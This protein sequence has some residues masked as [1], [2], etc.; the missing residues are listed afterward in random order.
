VS[1]D[2]LLDLA[3][4]LTDGAPVDWDAAQGDAVAA[5]RAVVERLHQLSELAALHAAVGPAEPVHESIRSEQSEHPEMPLKWGPLEILDKIGRGSYGD[6]YRARDP[7][8]GREVALKLLRRPAGGTPSVLIHE[9][10]LL[11]RIRHPNVVTVYGADEFDGRTGLW[12]ELVPGETLEEELRRRGPFSAED[13]LKVAADLC[14]AVEAVHAAGLLHRDIKAQNVIRAEDGRFVLMDFGTGSDGE[15]GSAPALAG[16]PVYLAPETFA[17]AA[18]TTASDVYALGVLL[19]HLATG[20]YPIDGSDIMALGRAHAKGPSKSLVVLRADYPRAVAAAIDRALAPDPLARFGDVAQFRSSLSQSAR[21]GFG[22]R[23]IAIATAALL[24]AGVAVALL[25]NPGVFSWRAGSPSVS[26]SQVPLSIQRRFNIRAPSWEGSLATCTPLGPGAVSLCNL[27]DGSIRA[28]RTPASNRERAPHAVLSPDGRRVAYVWQVDQVFR[29]LRLIDADSANDRE[30][31][32][33]GAPIL[34]V[35]GWNRASNALVVVS[36]GDD[37]VCVELLEL[38]TAARQ[39]LRCD[40]SVAALGFASLSPDDRYLAY[41]KPRTVG[42]PAEDVWIRD[43]VTGTDRVVTDDVSIDRDV[44]WTPDGRALAFASNRHGTWGLFTIDVEN[45]VPEGS[46][47]LVRDLGRSMPT[48]LGFTRDGTLFV[49]MLTDLEDVLR[50]DVDLPAS[51]LG[52]PGRAEPTALDET[53]RSP[54]WSPDGQRFAYIAGGPRADARIVIASAHGGV[55]KA[56]TF[57]GMPSRYEIVRWSPDGRTLAVSAHLA[58]G[59]PVSTLDLIDLRNSERRRVLVADSIGDLRWAPNGKGIYY[60][61]P[62]AIHLVDLTT[63]VSR[64]VYRPD[65]PWAIERFATFDL[66]RDGMALVVAIRTKGVNCAARIITTT[67]EVRDL[68]PFPSDCRAIAWTHDEQ[69][70]LASVYADDGSI[71][72]Y[73]VPVAGGAKPVRLQSPR[74][75]VVD[76]SVSPDG[77]QLLLGSGNPRPD[78]WTLSGFAPGVK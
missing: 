13:L 15:G 8:L 78:V 73:I 12:M 16:T 43:R 59:D 4:K 18:P 32:A 57:P 17:G 72:V 6:V 24:A 67:G 64:E 27:T 39:K 33:A 37:G 48:L 25:L 54:D 44:M 23:R 11:A 45:G 70:V 50:T 47:A 75:Q 9:G 68:P 76:I 52:N 38:E 77:R 63:S 21:R 2:P 42:Q 60:Y 3:L 29:S 28:V 20:A 1:T 53:N 58:A 41:T 22:P 65:K 74:I 19:F 7:R 46:P 69:A 34:S 30:L 40:A 61:M 35:W 56:L 66:S 36:G 55:E 71:P 49:R 10:H 31:V 62:G 5:D 26:L 14:G 51:S